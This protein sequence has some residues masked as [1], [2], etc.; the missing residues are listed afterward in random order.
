MPK[1]YTDDLQPAMPS[2]L[3][4]PL[5]IADPADHGS[6]IRIDPAGSTIAAAGGAQFRRQI[7]VPYVRTYAATTPALFG[8]AIT[9]HYVTAT[10]I[11]GFYLAPL[12][13]PMDMDVSKPSDVKL[14]AAS[15]ADD[16]GSGEVI[17]F[18]LVE[19]HVAD[20]GAPVDITVSCDWAVPTNWQMSDSRVVTIDGGSGYTFAG[21]TFQHGM[22]VGLR[23]TRVGS[24][25]EDT[26]DKTVNIGGALMFEYTAGRF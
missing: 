14:L 5:L 9:S 25:T 17:R 23:I 8:A 18:S 4:G 13:I 16:T 20:T 6:W 21:A 19:T 24:A 1:T 12:V 22:W 3:E 7:V 11:G 2:A 26:F 15:A 10:A